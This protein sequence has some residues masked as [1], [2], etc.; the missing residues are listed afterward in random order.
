[1]EKS[2][3]LRPRYACALVCGLTFLTYITTLWFHF[4]YDDIPQV[5]ENAAVHS[6]QF[7]GSYF[8]GDLWSAI[9]PNAPSGFYRPLFLVWI[10]LN[11]ALF[12][13]NPMPWHLTSVTLHTVATCFVFFLARRLS[14][15]LSVP[16]IAALIFGVHPVHVEVVA[17]ISDAC[18]SLMTI[19][20]IA[21]VLCF[22]KAGD[23]KR[24]R[25]WI[26]ASL[27]CYALALLAKEPAASLPLV[28]FA[29]AYL[30][31]NDNTKK[32]HTSLSTT[33]PY[34]AVTAV[35][36]LARAWALGGF[37]HAAANLGD[38]EIL[39]TL[40]SVIWLYIRLLVFPT[41]LSLS[42]GMPY[43][44]AFGVRHV[45]LPALLILVTI[46]LLYFWSRRSR[47][48]LIAFAS[49]WIA[50]PLLPVLN[51]RVLVP[52]DFVHDRYL[53]LP[54]VGFS[55]LAAFAISSL[56]FENLRSSIRGLQPAIATAI[57][58]LLAIGAIK[59][60][61]FWRSDFALFQRAASIAPE[62]DIALNNYAGMLLVNGRFQD[63][64]PLYE[65]VS[66]N[67]PEDWLACRNL[68]ITYYRL[69]RWSEAEAA[70][71]HAAQ[72]RSDD[73]TALAFLGAAN[74]QLGHFAAAEK[75]L[76]KAI[77]M[78]PQG[79]GYHYFLGMVL[80]KEGSLD[81]A[82]QEYRAELANYPQHN[83]AK[84]R[85]A[86]LTGPGAGH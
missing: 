56:R 86:Q 50:A 37:G 62:N 79:M 3:A 4:N 69:G 22:I 40:P 18:D 75:D 6:W 67:F 48:P 5:L 70:L 43:I 35:Y 58:V 11:Y 2:G 17:W 45:I 65:K 85:L 60:Q 21:A 49:V 29:Y 16:V 55:M 59:Q 46:F 12:G 19:F 73:S 8:T 81:A 44:V 27:F 84:L 39:F 13:G 68:G 28:I 57:I 83:G 41:G 51:L 77:Q 72:L 47:D 42:Y 24:P 78:F 31:A 76:R 10:R 64:L 54:S 33:I 14:R 26:A 52:G 1:M 66:Q 82:E 15:N 63:A 53:Y 20:F 30:Y 34:L 23:H 71:S 9:Q 80:E 32:W 74:M 25:I 7:L 61:L 38:R 36:L